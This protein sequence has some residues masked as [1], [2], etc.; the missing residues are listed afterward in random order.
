MSDAGP[1]RI[2]YAEMAAWMA[3]TGNQPTE[4]EIEAI[5]RIDAAFIAEC[6]AQARRNH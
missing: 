3:L 1:L 5:R 6:Q 4:L 2:T